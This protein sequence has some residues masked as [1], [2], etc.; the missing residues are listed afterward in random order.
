MNIKSKVFSLKSEVV[1]SLNAD[2][3]GWTLGFRLQTGDS[4]R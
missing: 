3:R 1:A 2:G 4:K